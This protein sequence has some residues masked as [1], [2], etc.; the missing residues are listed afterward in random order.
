[1]AVGSKIFVCFNTF[2]ADGDI[3]CRNISEAAGIVVDDANLWKIAS[4]CAMCVSAKN[5]LRVQCM[6]VRCCPG[7]YDFACREPLFIAVFYCPCEIS[8]VGEQDLRT[9]VYDITEI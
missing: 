3:G 6:C 5:V 1:M 4:Q 8:L 9:T 2:F 7:S